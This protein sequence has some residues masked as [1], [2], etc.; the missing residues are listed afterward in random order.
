MSRALRSRA[1][2]ALAAAAAVSALL[3]GPALHGALQHTHPGCAAPAAG[4]ELAAPEAALGTSPGVLACPLCL[5]S[6][7]AR[8]LL[9]RG[10]AVGSALRRDAVAVPHPPAPPPLPTP[11]ARAV[12]APRA[13]PLFT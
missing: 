6:G 12:S 9:P 13:P 7:Q 3:V 8:T 2:A 1:L 4:C 10:E 11:L 5:A